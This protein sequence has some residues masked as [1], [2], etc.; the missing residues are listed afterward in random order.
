[1]TGA[2]L[3]L[4]LGCTRRPAPPPNRA[5]APECREIAGVEQVTAPGKLVFFGEIH[6]TN[7]VPAFVGDVAC[8]ASRRGPVHLG[9]ELPA[10]DAPAL[11][12]FLAGDGD[13]G[14]RD[15]RF[16]RKTYQDGRSSRA[17]LALLH[18]VRS[19]RRAGAPI[20]VFLFDDPERKPR[21]EA[22]AENIARERQ[23]APSDLYLIEVGNYHARRV[24]GAPWDPSVRWLASFL[25]PREPGMLALDLRALPGTAWVCS[26]DT[27]ET[28]GDR[29]IRTIE[30]VSAVAGDLAVKLEPEPGGA[31]DGTFF[32]GRI[33]ASPPA[34]PA[35]D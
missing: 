1:M 8:L 13:V 7:E 5:A 2:S 27:P 4:F 20:E 6:G 28:C 11:R 31:Y 21:D 25:A 19:L 16:W 26:G 32:V 22:M 3:L 12:T 30:N 35:K 34:F 14:L 17:M 9:L 10:G 23:R 33:T 24:P 18:R 29:P 15:A